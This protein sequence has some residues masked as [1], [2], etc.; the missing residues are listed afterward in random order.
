MNALDFGEGPKSVFTFCSQQTRTSSEAPQPAFTLCSASQ[1][2]CSASQSS[3]PC[4]MGPCAPNKNHN[5]PN[6]ASLKA[7]FRP[8][9]HESTPSVYFEGSP[10]PS[11]CALKTVKLCQLT[12]FVTKYLLLYISRD[13][14]DTPR[15]ICYMHYKIGSLAETR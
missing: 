10:W 5:Q 9:S 7:S 15:H 12:R 1:S 3:R 11:S 2:R 6:A 14:R 8:A 4:S 13:V